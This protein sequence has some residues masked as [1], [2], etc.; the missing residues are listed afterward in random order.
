MDAKIAFMVIVGSVL[1]T[2]SCG[3]VCYNPFE[4]ETGGVSTPLPIQTLPPADSFSLKKTITIDN[5]NVE[6]ASNLYNFPVLISLTETW[7][8]L[9]PSGNVENEYGYDIVFFTEDVQTQ[10]NHQIEWYV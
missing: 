5:T 10:L 9:S 7:L 1:F 4:Q 3:I 8:R 2:M 6:G